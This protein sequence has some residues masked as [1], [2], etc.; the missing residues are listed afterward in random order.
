MLD[1]MHDSP[2]RGFLQLAN[3]QPM[4]EEQLANAAGVQVNEAR[5]L[6]LELENSGVFS[7]TKTGIIFNRKMVRDDSKRRKC[8]A[9]GK[10]GGNPTLKGKLNRM[11]YGSL[12]REIDC[13]SLSDLPNT[14]IQKN[15]PKE[16]IPPSVP[17]E[18]RSPAALPQANNML[19]EHSPAEQLKL[20]K[21]QERMDA[22]AEKKRLE[23]LAA[24]AV[25]DRIDELYS[26]YPKKTN[27]RDAKSAIHQALKRAPFDEIKAG[28]LKYVDFRRGQDSQ[29]T[30]GTAAWFRGDGWAS[31]MERA[32][33]TNPNSKMPKISRP[34][35]IPPET[36][37]DTPDVQ[38]PF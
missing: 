38:I 9:A 19:F 1:L 31:D 37:G 29:F 30:K 15:V 16:H 32:G 21:A 27:P 33:Y 28:L 14:Q 26:L 5:Q 8:R 17:E 18:Q 11:A 13:L 35:D 10:K 6:V 25:Q 23:R 36:S 24:A 2:R 4:S 3:G 34:E 12:V 20:K 7:R 22:K